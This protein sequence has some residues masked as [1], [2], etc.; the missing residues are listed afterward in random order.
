MACLNCVT[1]TV[2]RPIIRAK[3]G[4]I[5][6]SLRLSS[7]HWK[8]STKELGICP[9][10]Q[11]MVGACD[12]ALEVDLRPYHRCKISF[13]SGQVTFL[14]CTLSYPTRV[15]AKVRGQ[16]QA[17]RAGLG[18]N[19]GL[20]ASNGNTQNNYRWLSAEMGLCEYNLSQILECGA[21]HH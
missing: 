1:V 12:G 17:Q 5:S 16:A 13:G 15:L 20:S 2:R 11:A 19:E 3:H 4:L 8:P 9:A 7:K 14:R 10:V 18:G 6:Q 21:L